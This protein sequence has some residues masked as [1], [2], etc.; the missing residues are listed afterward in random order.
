MCV[1]Q[2]TISIGGQD[3]YERVNTAEIVLV[4]ARQPWK[5][6]RSLRVPRGF[7]EKFSSKV[8]SS[9][10]FDKQKVLVIPMLVSGYWGLR[11]GASSFPL[12]VTAERR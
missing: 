8:L 4:L 2:F 6:A 10:D 3:L 12:R 9:G 7:P 1:C 5:A 11:T